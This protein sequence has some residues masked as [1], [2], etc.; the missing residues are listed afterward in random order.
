MHTF[1][2]DG[3]IGRHIFEVYARHRITDTAIG[4]SCTQRVFPIVQYVDAHIGSNIQMSPVVGTTMG[5][6]RITTG[7]MVVADDPQALYVHTLLSVIIHCGC[8]HTCIKVPGDSVFLHMFR[9]IRLQ[10]MG[11]QLVLPSPETVNSLLKLELLIVI[12]DV[13]VFQKGMSQVQLKDRTILLFLVFLGSVEDKLIIRRSLFWLYHQH[14][15]IAHTELFK[16][17]ATTQERQQTQVPPYLLHA[18][19]VTILL[20]LKYNVADRCTLSQ[21]IDIDMAYLYLCVE[22]LLDGISGQSDNL[23]LHITAVTDNNRRQQ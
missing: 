6:V 1:A 4:E 12:L 15:N 13:K 14:V 16:H 18:Q 17:D 19:H 8:H 9:H 22:F 7:L 10:M 11:R 21:Q 2:T 23:I 5:S 3:N 20:I